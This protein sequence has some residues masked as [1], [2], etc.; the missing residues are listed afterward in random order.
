MQRASER[1][2]EE[3]RTLRAQA[4]G[5][6]RIYFLQ[7]GTKGVRAAK[8]QRSAR[9][10]FAHPSS[11]PPSERGTTFTITNTIQMHLDSLLGSVARIV[12]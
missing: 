6:L 12:A 10:L 2:A 4:Y 9:T 5:L 7:S 1:S 11:A 3:Y 8:K